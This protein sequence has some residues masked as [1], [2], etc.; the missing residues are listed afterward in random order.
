[1]PLA[2]TN[3]QQLGKEG[4]EGITYIGTLTRH[5]RGTTLDVP[6][7][8]RKGD[9][10]AVKTF[11]KTKSVARIR[12]EAGLQQI[13]AQAGISPKVYGID[14]EKKCII[15]QMLA[16]L[17]V[18]T[19]RE[20]EL[21]EDMQYQICALMHRLDLAKVLHNDMNAHNVMLDTNGRPFMIDFGL[22]KPITPAMVKKFGE[23]PN[24]CVTLWGLARGF[25]RNKVSCPIMDQCIKD[26]DKSHYFEYGE[27]L[28]TTPR[29]KKRKR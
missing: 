20:G 3:G 7:H 2:W 1:M 21:P 5:F 4:K 27:S 18:E 8:L 19:Y 16:S 9:K 13:C 25:K 17:P 14:A 28:F 11:R 26:K 12:K 22:A 6:I 23:H 24:I 29:R 10:V 15:M